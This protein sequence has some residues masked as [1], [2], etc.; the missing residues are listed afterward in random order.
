MST[1]TRRLPAV[2]V[3]TAR[4]LA[5]A[6]VGVTMVA[7]LTVLRY[8]VTVAGEPPLFYG[9]VAASLAAAALLAALVRPR[10][11][12][13]VTAGLLA[14]GTYY[15]VVTLPP[16]F[17]LAEALGPMVA[18]AWSMLSGLSILRII[19]AGTWALAITPAPTLFA[20][21]LAF[22]RHYL[23]GAAVAGGTLGLFVLTGN[24]DAATTLI[25]AVGVAGAAGFGDLAG[26]TTEVAVDEG[27]RDV[28]FGLG[29]IVAVASVVDVVPEELVGEGGGGFG[30]L[31][32][33]GTTEANLLGSADSVELA[34]SISLSPD[35]RFAVE[36]DE[37]GYWRVGG[38]DRFTGD[39]W[40]RTGQARAY[41]G[42]RLATPPGPDRAVEQT[43]TME[44]RMGNMPALW[45]P[46]SVERSDTG[47][48]V[49]PDGSLR[50]VRAFREDESYTVV[51]RVPTAVPTELRSAGTDYPEDVVDRYTALPG[52]L[53]DRVEARTSR[54]TGNATNPYDTARVVE[55]WLS[56]NRGY[57]LDVDRP[58]GNVA[59][60]FLFE[61]EEGYCTYFATT[62]AVMLRT[63]GIPARFAV[64]YTAGERVAADRWVA[65]GLNAHAWVE[66]F[67]P[68]QGWIR[69]DPTPAGPA[70]RPSRSA[71]TT[72]GRRAS[73]PWTRTRR[74]RASGR[75]RPSRAPT[76]TRTRSRPSR[77][78]RR[79]ACASS[80]RGP[81]RRPPSPARTA[82]AGAGR[83]AGASSSRRYRRAN[84]SRSG[85]SSRS[86]R[87]PAR[88]SPG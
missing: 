59:D 15:Y 60:A 20:A 57:S 9:A 73:T 70:S 74:G 35:V 88:A 36:A 23:A 61:M 44:G 83:P 63:Q 64:G 34:G 39:G 45:K 14:A 62:M 12:A 8:I 31:G 17:D 29:G 47:A 54:I 66:V 80:P 10:T 46:R 28:L 22:R 7:Y 42:D 78:T 69:F 18:D 3:D 68:E 48:D 19:N 52:N 26:G 41:D 65:R 1:V 4:V 25:G 49:L 13:L 21:Y 30:G 6:S 87:P 75:R 77:R 55:Q 38:F 24:A 5:T 51:S 71:S 72:P 2:N 79:R 58:S 43:Y 11:A 82:P 76:P 33:G 85:P 27:R 40:V 32:G 37:P 16:S 56:N 84:S 50:P 53:P 81:T 67:F 86:A